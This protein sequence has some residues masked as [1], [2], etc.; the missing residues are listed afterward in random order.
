MFSF[1]KNYKLLY[2]I[3]FVRYIITVEALRDKLIIFVAKVYY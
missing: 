2:F 3:C 1:I